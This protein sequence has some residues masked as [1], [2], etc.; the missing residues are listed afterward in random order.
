[1]IS[2]KILDAKP[3]TI[4]S[5]GNTIKDLSFATLKSNDF[6]FVDIMICTDEQSMRPD[7]L[8]IAAFGNTERIEDLLKSND[9]SCPFAIDE[10]EIFLIPDLISAKNNYTSLGIITNVREKIR[11]QYIDISKTPDTKKM[12]DALEDF[13]NREKTALPPNIA[14]TGDKEMII[15]DGI[16]I[17]GPDVTRKRKIATQIKQHQE[18]LEKLQENG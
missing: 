2:P 15:K 14:K 18:Y 10:L 8:A 5:K 1:M 12:H 4:D 9:V 16:I 13:K 3:D 6:N 11:K 17:F 7:L